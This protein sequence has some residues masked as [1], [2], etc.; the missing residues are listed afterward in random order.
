MLVRHSFMHFSFK[1]TVIWF[2]PATHYKDYKISLILHK[3]VLRLCLFTKKKKREIMIMLNKLISD[4]KL[5][6]LTLA[7]N[8]ADMVLKK[9]QTLISQKDKN[10]QI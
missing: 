3:M 9:P 6:I 2:R 10:Q 7:S 5:I 4:K 8:R 1:Q